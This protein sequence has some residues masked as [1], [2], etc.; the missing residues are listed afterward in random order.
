MSAV[1][2][3]QSVKLLQSVAARWH[4]S[5]WFENRKFKGGHP[6]N[7]LCSQTLPSMIT[8]QAVYSKSY[9]FRLWEL[10]SYHHISKKIVWKYYYATISI[11]SPTNSGVKISES[12]KGFII[13]NNIC[14]PF[15]GFGSYRPVCLKKSWNLEVFY[16][17][18]FWNLNFE[19][20]KVN[21]LWDC[22][23]FWDTLWK[24]MPFL[25]F[26]NKFIIIS[27]KASMQNLDVNIKVSFKSQNAKKVFLPLRPFS[28]NLRQN[29]LFWIAPTYRWDPYGNFGVWKRWG[30]KPCQSTCNKPSWASWFV[31]NGPCDDVE[32]G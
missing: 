14:T 26:E 31:K 10:S 21:F 11:W 17:S 12:L 27:R 1:T 18:P 32:K 16:L 20:S 7:Y 19:I 29:V 9:K 15:L 5:K 4:C 30:N 23:S 3:A 8:W 13:C 28:N 22:W 25:S 24:G 6:W 2:S